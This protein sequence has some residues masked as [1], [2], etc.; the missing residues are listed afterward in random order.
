VGRQ[1]RKVFANELKKGDLI[2]VKT[3]ERLPA[4]GIIKQ[5]KTSIDEQLITGNML[6]TSKTAG[7][8]VYAGTLNKSDAVYIEVTEV[9][10]SSALMS[11]VDAIKKGEI[12]RSGFKSALDGFAAWLLPVCLLAAGGAYAYMLYK[13]G[14]AQWFHYLGMVF[15]SC[16]RAVLPGP[17][18]CFGGVSVFLCA[19]GR[20]GAEIKIKICTRWTKSCTPIPYFLIKTGTLSYGEL[21]VSGVYPR[22]R[23][24]KNCFWKR[25]PP[26]TASGRPVCGRRQPMWQR[27]QNKTPNGYY[28]L[29]SCPAGR[30]GHLRRGQKFWRA[31]PNGW[32]NRD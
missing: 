1:F 17:P 22:P 24:R 21:R 31:A 20:A 23:Y 28:V 6:P 14:T 16:A 18:W 10:A 15:Y 8:R 25:L 9:L 29:T 2:F 4:D 7:S 30:T 12:H 5:G 32:K 27:T 3:G 26:R 11:V 19:F 13:H